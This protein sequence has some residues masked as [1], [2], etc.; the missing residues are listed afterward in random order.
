[1]K[2]KREEKLEQEDEEDK[3]AKG[4]WEQ[5]P[6]PVLII[7]GFLLFLAARSMLDS[8]EKGQ[9]LLMGMFVIGMM[10]FLSK[11]RPATEGVI[12]PME[13]EI[14]T[15]RELIRKIKWGQLPMGTKYSIGPEINP[16]H[17]NARGMFYNLAVAIQYPWTNEI[18]HYIA[19][20]MMRGDEKGF[21]SFVGNVGK[22]TGRE[23]DQERSIF[24]R[25]LAHAEKHP[26][27]ARIVGKVGGF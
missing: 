18:K 15:E 26:E 5:L 24:P 17:R 21:V 2:E 8:E 27:F 10:Y 19:K 23:M 6:T 16:M 20:I 7:G 14:L 4:W 12:S 25:W 13:A 22:V 11:T 1:M 9:Y 3:T